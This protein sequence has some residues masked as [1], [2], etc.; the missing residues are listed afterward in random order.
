MNCRLQTRNDPL[1]T[2][3]ARQRPKPALHR[4]YLSG[5]RPPG[6]PPALCAGAASPAPAGAGARAGSGS[7]PR[8]R[9]GWQSGGQ[10][11]GASWPGRARGTFE[12]NSFKLKTRP[13]SGA[14]AAV[15]VCSFASEVGPSVS[16]GAHPR[17]PGTDGGPPSRACRRDSE[18]KVARQIRHRGRLSPPRR[19]PTEGPAPSHCGTGK[20]KLA[21]SS[22]RFL[23][24]RSVGFAAALSLAGRRRAHD[25]AVLPARCQRAPVSTPSLPHWHILPA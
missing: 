3:R 24:A 19:G 17:W 4:D 9:S 12:M 23:A 15:A 2:P 10:Q 22:F 11:R 21:L 1:R 20:F 14:L 5:A 8:S 18:A 25:L 16:A 13:G 6:V 7:R